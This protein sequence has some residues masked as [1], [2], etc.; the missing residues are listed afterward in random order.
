MQW[1]V[2]L[3]RAA[4]VRDL[5]QSV[6]PQLVAAILRAVHGRI[7]CCDAV[8]KCQPLESLETT[9]HSSTSASSL[10]CCSLAKDFEEDKCQTEVGGEKVKGR[11]PDC[12]TF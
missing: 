5:D 4:L 12:L 8:A 1:K 2:A 11:R 7:A 3:A 6:A 10:A 9:D